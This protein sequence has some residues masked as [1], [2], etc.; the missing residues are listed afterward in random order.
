HPTDSTIEH[1]HYAAAAARGRARVVPR[2]WRHRGARCRSCRRLAASNSSFRSS[3]RTAGT[4]ARRASNP[5]G[6]FYLPALSVFPAAVSGSMS[7]NTCPLGGRCLAFCRDGAIPFA[8]HP[9]ST[10]LRKRGLLQL[11]F[12]RGHISPHFWNAEAEPTASLV[13]FGRQIV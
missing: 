2:E 10:T 7:S 5:A 9:R 1:S 3:S 12:R 4:W 8:E 13:P 11:G 6:N